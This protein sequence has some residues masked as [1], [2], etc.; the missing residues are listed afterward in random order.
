MGTY[1]QLHD[2][3]PTLQYLTST[4]H[5]SYSCGAYTLKYMLTWDGD[6]ITEDFTQ[7]E[8][9]IFS[10]KICS[11]LLRSDCNKLRKKSYKNPIEKD[12][13]EASIPEE[14]KGADDDVT[15]VSNPDVTNKPDTS[16]APKCKRGR[17]RKN[18]PPSNPVKQQFDTET[19]AKQVESKRRKRKPSNAMSS[20][21]VQP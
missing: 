12:E 2:S 11:S 18:A 4:L 19:I 16:G 9:H 6:K 17:P 5:H 8:I 3:S 15:I 13:Y 20:P 10:W 14:R 1:R 7:A 21:F